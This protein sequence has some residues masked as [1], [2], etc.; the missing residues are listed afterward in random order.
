MNINTHIRLHDAFLQA[1]DRFLDKYGPPDSPTFQND[2]ETSLAH[3]TRHNERGLTFQQN[4]QAMPDDWDAPDPPNLTDTSRNTTSP[5]LIPKPTYAQ[6]IK[7]SYPIPKKRQDKVLPK[8]KQLAPDFTTPAPDQPRGPSKP[9]SPN[10]AQPPILDTP[11]PDMTSTS[12]SPLPANTNQ[13]PDI[14]PQPHNTTSDS[15]YQI[16]PL[17]QP[18]KFDILQAQFSHLQNLQNELKQHMELAYPEFQ[19][20]QQQQSMPIQ[21]QQPV[22]Y[23][24][25]P[26]PQPVQNHPSQPRSPAQTPPPMFHQVPQHTQVQ[27]PDPFMVLP[28]MP[29]LGHKPSWLHP[30]ETIETPIPPSSLLWACKNDQMRP[31]W[32]S[33]RHSSASLHSKVN[34]HL[35]LFN[36]DRYNT[37]PNY[38]QIPIDGVNS[39]SSLTVQFTSDS[40]NEQI[41]LITSTRP[42]VH[43]KL[44]QK[45]KPDIKETLTIPLSLF[46]RFITKF[47]E[48]CNQEL[49][50]ADHDITANTFTIHTHE[51]SISD[52]MFKSSIDIR[53]GV[54]GRERLTTIARTHNKSPP[55]YPNESIQ[56]PWV[57]LM[58]AL[59]AMRNVHQDLLNQQIL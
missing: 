7:T 24:T 37:K 44:N 16:Q 6:K 25:V 2:N 4:A 29:P 51:Y 20:Q 17:K 27:M 21:P 18:S 47:F 3:H 57:H 8:P 30:S 15:K 49:I 31:L 39:H 14:Q 9:P 56:I 28:N 19:Q 53:E 38:R 33:Q 42:V 13:Q 11:V 36:P 52:H 5:S 54:H 43:P 41:Q 45:Y 34:R 32:T 35:P 1:Y 23:V 46:N 59:A 55:D 50:P 48:L 26:Q 10:P 12:T 40:H 58:D 22:F